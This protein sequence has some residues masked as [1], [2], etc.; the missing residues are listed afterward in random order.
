MREFLPARYKWAEPRRVGCSMRGIIMDNEQQFSAET[1]RAYQI[2]C[3]FCS[4]TLYCSPDPASVDNF[5]AQRALFLEEPFA[6]VAP[7]ASGVLYDL[8]DGAQ[9]EVQRADLLVALHR[10]YTYLFYMVGISH[11]SPYESVYRTDDRTMFGPT[12]LE[13]R[14]IYRVHGQRLAQTE[15][16][17]DDHIG[18]E[19]SFLGSLFSQLIEQESVKDI[20]A[21]EATL[22]ALR[23]FLSDHLLVFA[24]VYL[25]NVQTRADTDFYRSVAVI[26]EKFLAHMAHTLGIEAGASIDTSAY[27]LLS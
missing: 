4:K 1:L 18:I 17:P 21:A 7:Q 23:A 16:Q 11:T 25:A 15:N 6:S 8:L 24:P 14:E 10:D 26:A 19:F 12:T 20:N 2:L 5:I 22:C 3:E 27:L 13:V 9:S